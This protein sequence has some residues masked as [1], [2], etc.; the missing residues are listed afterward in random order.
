M[1]RLSARLRAILTAALILGL[2]SSASA[3]ADY[4]AV[5]GAD[6][7]SV[8]LQQLEDAGIAYYT[9]SPEGGTWQL[10]APTMVGGIQ[11]N[12]WISS[13]DRDP[14]VTNNFNVTNISGLTQTFS[15]TILSPVVPTGPQTSMTGSVGLTL[16][17]TADTTALV[18]SLAPN[19]VYTALIDGV[20]V[21]TLANHP[22]TL[23]CD[24]PP[25]P[26]TPFCTGTS[27]GLSFSNVLGPAAASTIGITIQ[28]QLSPGDSAGV[29][30]VFNITAVPEPGTLLLVV[31]GVV[32][33][34][35]S[36]RRRRAA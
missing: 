2:A 9:H 24:T 21:Q 26:V 6:G 1:T 30:S 5:F 36:G 29:T 13:Y 23:T 33:L 20:N 10:A 28:F 18:T 25:G 7:S 34:V 32:G 31:G 12:S 3:L 15:V 8:T 35:V 14:F 22:F 19:A 27:S 16:T 11:I 4:T 17:N